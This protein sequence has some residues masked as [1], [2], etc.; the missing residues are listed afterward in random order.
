MT[1]IRESA[2]LDWAGEHMKPVNPRRRRSQIISQL[3]ELSRNGWA[4]A[5]PCD[6]E[7]LERELR[8]LP[9][10]PSAKELARAKRANAKKKDD[11][12]KAEKGASRNL[13]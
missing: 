8:K 9:R 4:S 7:P 11:I 3:C 1:P 12:D 6:Y 10:T 5:K 2:E 13:R